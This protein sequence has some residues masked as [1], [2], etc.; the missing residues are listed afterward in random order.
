MIL[1]ACALTVVLLNHGYAMVR[2]DSS[3]P[4]VNYAF[5]GF[6]I[7]TLGMYL[8]ARIIAENRE[9][10]HSFESS[11]CTVALVAANLFTVS[12]LS[13][14]IVTFV[15]H[16]ESLRDLLLVGLW[17]GYGCLA[18]VVGVWRKALLPRL[19]AYA[20]MVAGVGATVLLLNH[21]HA[22]I[23]PE[24]C[25]PIVN[26]SFA[27]FAIC[28]IALYLVARVIADNR[29]R[30]H[31]SEDFV[32]TAALVA[33]NVLTVCA[34]SAEIVTFV[35][36]SVNLRNLLLVALWMAYGCLLTVV[37]VWRKALLPRL[38][39]YALD[40]RRGRRD[41]GPAGS[42]ACGCLAGG[43]EADS[44]LQLRWLR[45]LHFGSVLGCPRRLRRTGTSCRTSRN[46]SASW[47]SWLPTCSRSGP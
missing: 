42:V 40:G 7:C 43:L 38:G 27:G 45:H 6:A 34:L 24:D 22:G 3:N 10:L 5:G 15:R 25:S 9:R 18:M 20:L 17:M 26:Y 28:T 2:I 35:N 4:M 21:W 11:I 37:G 30:L 13:A 44:Q 47:R 36:Y 33:A 29:E 32:G 16:P 31:K 12:A 23:N 46:S 8:A 19:G 1:A 41:S 39:G 14:E